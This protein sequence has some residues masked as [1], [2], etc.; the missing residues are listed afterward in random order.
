MTG[1]TKKKLN[2][3][4]QRRESVLIEW[5]QKDLTTKF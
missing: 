5:L 2:A 1:P 4:K 3:I